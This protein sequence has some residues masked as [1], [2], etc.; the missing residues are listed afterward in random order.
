M[1]F[2][3]PHN[4]DVDDEEL[5]QSIKYFLTEFQNQYISSDKRFEWILYKVEDEDEDRM[6]EAE[7]GEEF[8]DS[9][10]TVVAIFEGGF[11]YYVCTQNR[12]VPGTDKLPIMV[13]KSLIIRMREFDDYR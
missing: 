5:Y 9:G 1:D 3:V 8:G 4:G 6:M 13:N 12:G 7:V 2:H 10:E 11:M